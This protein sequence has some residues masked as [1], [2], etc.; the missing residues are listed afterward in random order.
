MLA[1][2]SSRKNLVPA[3]M[4]WWVLGSVQIA[5]SAVQPSLSLDLLVC[6]KFAC[7]DQDFGSWSD[8]RDACHSSLFDIVWLT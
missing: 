2:L 8:I 4:T 6:Q 3:K 5:L 1:A 7:A